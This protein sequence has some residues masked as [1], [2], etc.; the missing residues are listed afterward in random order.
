LVTR[1]AERA[2]R[3][4]PGRAEKAQRQ[5]RAKRRRDADLVARRRATAAEKEREQADREVRQREDDARLDAEERARRALVER[6][7]A[8]Y[9]TVRD[10]VSGVGRAGGETVDVSLAEQRRI[11]ALAD[12]RDASLDV[13]AVLRQRC[14]PI[15]GVRL[16]DYDV[17]SS[18]RMLR[19]KREVS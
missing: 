2:A 10:W 16:A 11:G 18:D 14:E 6:A 9:R 17:P 8:N 3:A 7:Y 5:E 12:L 19:L 15:S 1:L 4:A 13:I